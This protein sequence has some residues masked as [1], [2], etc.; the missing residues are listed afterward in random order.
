[1]LFC[2]CHFYV[3]NTKVPLTD[4]SSNIGRELKREINYATCPET[5]QFNN[6]IKNDP[7]V[8][9]SGLIKTFVVHSF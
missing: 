1:M 4:S 2:V 5:L 7:S 6:C 3:V 8:R 9:R